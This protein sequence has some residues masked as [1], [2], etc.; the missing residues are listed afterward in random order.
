[1]RSLAALLTLLLA[2]P[3]SASDRRTEVP[4][5]VSQGALVVGSTA[6]GN[7]V[8]LGEQTLRVD[9]EGRFVFGVGRD[10]QGP[11]RLRID[12]FDGAVEQVNLQVFPRQWKIE[13]V[14]G[15]P[16]GTVSPPPEIAERIAREQARVSAARERDDARSD[17]ASGFSW[18]LRGRI[19]G[20]FGSQRIYNGE[21][22]APHSGLDVAAPNGTPLRAP[23][24]GI[25]SFADV[26]LYL[27]GGT[28]LIDHGHGVSSNFLHLSRIDV[29]P[30]QRV[31][32]GQVIGAVGATGR[33]TGPHMHWG[34]NW[35]GVRIDP[36]PLVELQAGAAGSEQ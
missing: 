30:G 22:R 12:W 7:R 2:L 21:P 3:A 17:F 20:E 5:A 18:P 26:D 10:E 23:A 28:V 35:F 13:R 1:M 27:T 11:L 14:D 16:P 24:A 34:M 36:Q 19:S 6:S 32:Q 31:E 25:V 8:M 33:A 29:K 15:V 4:A 9:A